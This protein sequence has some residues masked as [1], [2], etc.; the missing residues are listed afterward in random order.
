MFDSVR[1]LLLLLLLLLVLVLV[2]LLLLLL[3]LV[4]VL[5]VLSSRLLLVRVRVLPGVLPTL[6]TL[7]AAG[8]VSAGAVAVVLLLWLPRTMLSKRAAAASE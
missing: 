6:I 3:L 4:L 2:V 5:L 7:G 1:L 8:A